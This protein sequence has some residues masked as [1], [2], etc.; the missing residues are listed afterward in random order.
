MLGMCRYLLSRKD[1]PAALEHFAGIGENCPERWLEAV[2][3]VLGLYQ[4]LYAELCAKRSP[5]SLWTEL[6]KLSEGQV[7]DRVDPLARF[8]AMA[9][10]PAALAGEQHERLYGLLR[11]FLITLSE[12]H[13]DAITRQ[14]LS[15]VRVMLPHDDLVNAVLDTMLSAGFER[16]RCYP[17]DELVNG[18]PDF[19]L[20]AAARYCQQRGINI[21]LG[22]SALAE[23]MIYMAYFRPRPAKPGAVSRPIELAT[24][25]NS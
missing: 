12:L 17:A 6:A 14:A 21:Q 19:C 15:L 13:Q 2:E 10:P 1:L 23:D 16:R 3:G 25:I 24:L 5:H 8:V 22:F 18:L 20:P 7:Y 4:Q 9:R 11:D